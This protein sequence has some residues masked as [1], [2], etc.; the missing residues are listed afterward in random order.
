MQISRR[1]HRKTE[2]TKQ[3]LRHFAFMVRRIFCCKMPDQTT[4]WSMVDGCVALRITGLVGTLP[5][6]LK[7]CA[8]LLFHDF[9]GVAK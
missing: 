2:N 6:I 9:C 3:K 5:L 8:Q 4:P 7:A 1:L